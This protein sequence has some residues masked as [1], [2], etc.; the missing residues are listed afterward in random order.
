MLVVRR[1][2]SHHRLRAV[3]S[4][5]VERRGVFAKR[6]GVRPLPARPNQFLE[7]YL[8][9]RYLVRMPGGAFFRS[10]DVAL[11]GPMTVPVAELAF[12]GIIETFTI[13]FQP[14]GLSRLF[15]VPMATLVNEAPPAADVLGRHVAPLESAIRRAAGFEERVAAAQDWAGRLLA[16]ARGQDSIDFAA[17]ILA[18]TGG[19]PS[20]AALA[21]HVEMSPRQL[22]RR[23]VEAVGMAPKQY[24]RLHRFAAA[25]T[26]K[27]VGH[28]RSW[29]DIAHACGFADQAHLIREFH[30]LSGRAPGDFFRDVA[31]VPET[32]ADPMS[33]IFKRPGHR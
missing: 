9:E 11:V 26:A 25:I 12:D 1:A 4:G 33:E 27:D 15:G 18:R 22:Q 8:A 28:A 6:S 16:D 29:T 10:P 21:E 7:F 17:R 20:I 32:A 14:T 5:F 2:P 13:H 24:A 23:F 31:D 3:V 30:A 19:R